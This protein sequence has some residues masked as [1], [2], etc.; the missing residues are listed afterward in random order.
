ML[1]VSAINRAKELN[2]HPM[3][4]SMRQLMTINIPLEDESTLSKENYYLRKLSE[5]LRK[6]SREWQSSLC[7]WKCCCRSSGETLANATKAAGACTFVMPR[8]ATRKGAAKVQLGF[9][10]IFSLKCEKLS[11]ERGRMKL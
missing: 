2:E 11:A 8:E 7:A 3:T 4:G 1:T 9:V 6:Y 10:Q 5:K